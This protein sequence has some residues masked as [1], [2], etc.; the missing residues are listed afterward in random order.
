MSNFDTEARK[1]IDDAIR[2]TVVDGSDPCC[3]R[4]GKAFRMLQAQRQVPGQSLNMPLAAAEH[5]M[6]ARFMVCAGAVSP[7]QMRALVVGYDL[8]KALDKARGNP[9]KEQVT[10]NPVSPPS[11]DVVKW[12][13]KGVSE[14]S[15]DHDRCNAKLKPPLWTDLEKIFGPGRSIEVAGKKY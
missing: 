9:D 4:L 2:S 10:A 13:L 7:T 5:Y 12:G 14:G 15:A 11:L 1:M 6:F 3:G 8:K